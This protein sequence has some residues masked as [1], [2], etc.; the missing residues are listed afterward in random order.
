M[1]TKGT[2]A[3]I[4]TSRASKRV[5]SDAFEWASKEWAHADGPEQSHVEQANSKA[6]YI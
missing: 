5:C 4:R 6:V 3:F 1:K 2:Q